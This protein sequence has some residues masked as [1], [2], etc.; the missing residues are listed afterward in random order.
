MSLY[1][2]LTISIKEKNDLT[3]T[4]SHGDADEFGDKLDSNQQAEDMSPVFDV[5]ALVQSSIMIKQHQNII[6]NTYLASL[7][8]SNN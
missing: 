4:H 3:H 7:T 5:C 8:I 6:L 1:F 2:P